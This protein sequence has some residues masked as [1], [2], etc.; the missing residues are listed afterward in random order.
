MKKEVSMT[1]RLESEVAIIIEKMA[2]EDERSI[3]YIIRMLLVEA[4]KQRKLLP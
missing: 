3:S 1:V 2:K 4:L